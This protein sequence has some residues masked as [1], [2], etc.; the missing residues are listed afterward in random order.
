MEQKLQELEAAL[1]KHDWY[2]NMSDDYSVYS[3]GQ[4]N[5]NRIQTLCRELHQAGLQHQADA[6]VD[7]Y[8][9]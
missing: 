2:F 1:V 8:R 6:L 9:K 7:K 3:A 5:S 4:A